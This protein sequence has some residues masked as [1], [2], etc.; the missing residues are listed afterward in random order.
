MKQQEYIINGK[1][2]AVEIISVDGQS[3]QVRVNDTTY[4][5]D[6][7]A[8]ETAAPRP[9][10]PAPAAPPPASPAPAAP[11]PDMAPMA[12]AEGQVTSP[13]PGVILKLLVKEGQAVA[14]G[15]TLM[16]LE[17]MKMENEIHANRAGTVKKI[18]VGE[19]NEVRAGVPLIDLE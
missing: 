5:V 13:M 9:S 11:A 19:G 6:M 1:S 4:Q 10:A 7:A 15:E 12:A 16:I 3:A 18:H 2:F 14:A 17:A 8:Q